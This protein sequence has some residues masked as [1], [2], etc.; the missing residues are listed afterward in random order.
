MQPIKLHSSHRWILHETGEP[1]IPGGFG[2][3]GDKGDRGIDGS[4]GNPGIKG[5]SGRDGFD[6]Q[7]GEPGK[8]YLS[9][10]KQAKCS[11]TITCLI[12][13]SLYD[14]DVSQL[15]SYIYVNL[16]VPKVKVVI[17]WALLKLSK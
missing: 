6:G 7:A 16:L 14:L 15:I 4:P 9:T 13:Y 11:V 5:E 10:I 3:K 8:V 1:G 17:L 12:K 2:S